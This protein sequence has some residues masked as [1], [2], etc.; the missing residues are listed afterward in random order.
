MVAGCVIGPRRDQGHDPAA[1]IVLV[2]RVL[3]SIYGAIR[4]PHEPAGRSIRWFGYQTN[5]GRVT[6]LVLWPLLVLAVGACLWE[7]GNRRPR[8]ESASS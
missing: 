8:F 6:G 4:L 3:R 1:A 7:V 2:A 5:M